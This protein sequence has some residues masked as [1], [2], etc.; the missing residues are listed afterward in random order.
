M[1]QQGN[2]D[3]PTAS[4]TNEEEPVAA[5]PTAIVQFFKD[6]KVEIIKGALA[7]LQGKVVLAYK[8]KASI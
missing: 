8:G 3:E 2:R 6:D 4:Q 5:P 7:G 1:F